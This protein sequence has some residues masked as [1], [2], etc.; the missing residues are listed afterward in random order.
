V[1]EDGPTGPP[2]SPESTASLLIKVQSGDDAARE[3]LVARYLPILLRWAHGRLPVRARGM[4]DTN[5]LVQVTLLKAL[6]RVKDFESRGE[7]AFLAYLRRILQSRIIDQLRAAERKPEHEEPGE[8]I[9]DGGRSPLEEAVGAEILEA[10][11]RGLS[12]LSER[13][14]EAVV[15]R[16]ELGFTHEQVAEAIGSPSSDAARMLVTRALVRLAEVM[17]EQGQG[18]RTR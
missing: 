1:N 12:Q 9:Q 10:Y 11:E 4:V 15:L 16:L 6:E 5:D 8:Y 18:L 7:G 14:A 13:E 3:R 17:D 2:L